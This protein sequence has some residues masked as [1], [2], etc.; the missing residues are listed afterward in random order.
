M[1][2]DEVWETATKALQD[3]LDERGMEYKI[4]E[5]DGAFYGPKIDFHLRDSIGRTWQCGT[6]QLDM[7]MPENFDLNYIG[8]DGQKHRPVM[9]HRVAYGSLERFIGILIEHFAGAF[10]AWLA[11]VQVKIL[12]ITD[13]HMEYAKKV[14][15]EMWNQDIRVAVDERN[16]KIGYKIREAQM[17]KIPYV[18]VVGDKEME[19]GTVAVRKRGEGDLGPQATD[20]FTKQLLE[21]IAAKK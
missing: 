4:N 21:E 9:I 19:N 18:L 10:P 12:P 15:K 16:E 7:L 8:E 17:Q 5:G 3:A 11:P 13:R 6:I 2:S 1:G 20:V 14:A